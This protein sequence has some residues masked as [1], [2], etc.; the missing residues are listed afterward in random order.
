MHLFATST[1]E[2]ILQLG[3]MAPLIEV[4][5]PKSERLAVKS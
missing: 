2:Q 1:A 3:K 5:K 4:Q